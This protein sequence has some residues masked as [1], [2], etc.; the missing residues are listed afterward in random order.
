MMARFLTISVFLKTKTQG[1]SKA[2]PVASAQQLASEIGCLH[3]R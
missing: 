3:F 2:F 1:D